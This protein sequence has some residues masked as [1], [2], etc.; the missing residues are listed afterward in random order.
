MICWTPQPGCRRTKP[1]ARASTRRSDSCSKSF[2]A[3]GSLH[4]Y[5]GHAHGTLAPGRIVLTPASQ[6]VVLDWLYGPAVQR[7]QFNRR[8]LWLELGVATPPQPDRHGWI[9]S[10]DISQASL[11][12]MMIVLGRPLRKKSIPMRFPLSFPR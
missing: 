7:L 6:V 11:A 10:G 12:A 1:H 4:D 3:L 2:P 9:S 8:R 5:G